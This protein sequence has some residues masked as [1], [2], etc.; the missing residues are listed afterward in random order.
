MNTLIEDECSGLKSALLSALKVSHE[1]KVLPLQHF[2][3]VTTC[4]PPHREICPKCWIRNKA[5]PSTWALCQISNWIFPQLGQTKS[6]CNRSSRST[7]WN[8]WQCSEQPSLR[9]HCLCYSM[10]SRSATTLFRCPLRERVNVGSAGSCLHLGILVDREWG[11]SWYLARGPFWF[12]FGGDFEC[13]SLFL[14]WVLPLYQSPHMW[15]PRMRERFRLHTMRAV[16]ESFVIMAFIQFR[17][18][19]HVIMYIPACCALGRHA[20]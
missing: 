15:S 8:C 12:L 16:L 11:P 3:L 2:Y 6:A 18:L 20:N 5:L 17:P 14:C 1:N 10:Q 7:R 9:S 19:F 13:T 4:T